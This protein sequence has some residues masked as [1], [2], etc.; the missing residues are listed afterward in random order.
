MSASKN[1]T[2]L[3]SVIMNCFNG[4]K[5]LRESIDSVINQTYQNLELIFWDNK[6]EDESENIFKS[7]KDPRLKYF[8]SKEHT[9]LY[10]ARNLAIEKSQG[11]FIAFLDTDDLW[12]KKKL[13]LQINLFDEN[14]VGLVFSNYW[15]LKKNKKI[16]KIAIKNKLPNGKIY[17]KLLRNYNVAI[18]T[19]VIR[20]S[21]YLKLKE[22]FDERFTFIGD[23]D[24]FL[25]LSKIC[26]FKSVQ[27]PLAYYRLHGANLSTVNKN[28][29][30]MEFDLWIKE[31]VSHFDDKEVKFLLK[32]INYRKFIN[33]KIDKKYK[34]CISIFL[35][36]KNN[37]LSIKN[38][39]ILFTPVFVL[40]KFMWYHQ[41]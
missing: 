7:Y 40:K 4:E 38:L 34:E 14:E 13:D 12:D 24:L 10:R 22:K 29:E 25:R 1:S 3:V 36:S 37:L 39:I 33:F 18:L 8:C 41:D 20:K 21:H 16:K 31:N 26:I 23:F 5:F 32:N 11:D 19:A 15:L 35:N 6:S 27:L 2:P 9:P 17:N 30:T 28:K